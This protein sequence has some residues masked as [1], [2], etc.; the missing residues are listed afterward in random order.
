MKAL[1]AQPTRVSARSYP[2]R[3]IC[4]DYPFCFRIASDEVERRS[5]IQ[6]A[7]PIL[8]VSEEDHALA[9]IP[10]GNVVDVVEINR[11]S[12]QVYRVGGMSDLYRLYPGTMLQC[13]LQA[14]I[15]AGARFF[16]DPALASSNQVALETASP[17]QF[18]VVEG[19]EFVTSLSNVS[20]V[21]ISNPY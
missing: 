6:A 15:E 14:G 17:Q 9:L 18:L 2:A 21:P 1:V 10:R 20:C 5:F 7:T 8:L 4:H 11:L 3:W 16:V 19:E 13:L 12:G